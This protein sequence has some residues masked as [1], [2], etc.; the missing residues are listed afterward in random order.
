MIYFFRETT[1]VA[2]AFNRMPPAAMPAR[3][4]MCFVIVARTQPTTAAEPIKAAN[5]SVSTRFNFFS[6]RPS[7]FFNAF[8]M[9]S[10]DIVLDLVPN[11]YE[12]LWPTALRPLPLLPN[13]SIEH[14]MCHGLAWFDST[15]HDSPGVD[16][17][18][19]MTLRTLL[20]LGLADEH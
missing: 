11:R 2:I 3:R 15:L 17:I 10:S 20:L 18:M 7:S 19:W 4:G 1:R 9:W 16:P 6:I 12:S 5:R 8:S 13:T 14:K